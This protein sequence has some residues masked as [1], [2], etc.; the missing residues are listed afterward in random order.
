MTWAPEVMDQPAN[1]SG[2]AVLTSRIRGMLL[3]LAIGDALGNTSEGMLP[4]ERKSRYGEIRDYLPNRHAGGRRV[5][6]PSDDTQ[7]AFWTLEHLLEH[8]RIDPN[9]LADLFC[10]ERIFGIGQTIHSFVGRWRETHDWVASSQE[11]AGN[12]ALMRIA[13]VVALHA[14]DG[15]PDMTQRSERP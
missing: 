13:P 11:S 2:G 5:G 7:L 8:R 15:S 3:G 12:G 1:V 6:L 9:T 14:A 10:S 4:D